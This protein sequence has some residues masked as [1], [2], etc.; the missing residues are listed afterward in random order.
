[1]GLGPAR[2]VSL[3]EARVAAV[4]ASKLCR[5]GMDPIDVRR[6]R[7][8]QQD[9]TPGPKSDETA[10]YRH[11]D[12]D[13]RLLYVGISIQAFGR[14]CRH[15]KGSPWW[16]KIA[17]VTVEQFGSRSAAEDAELR[18][19]KTELPV[20]NKRHKPKIELV[21]PNGNPEGRAK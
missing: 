5:Q 17:R 6:A 8:D 15:Q 19:I 13:G 12:A 2:L 7:L 10:L 18:A 3:A 1:M 9:S 20:Y 14:L 4:E 16:L 21:E 11:F